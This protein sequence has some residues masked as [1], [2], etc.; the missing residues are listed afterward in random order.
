MFIVLVGPVEYGRPLE[1]LSK[2]GAARLQYLCCALEELGAWIYHI[3]V[4]AGR[5]TQETHGGSRHRPGGRGRP[6]GATT[7]SDSH[8]HAWLPRT[9]CR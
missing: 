5:G 2:C 8:R 3:G 1:H 6:V 4:L 7:G 9:A